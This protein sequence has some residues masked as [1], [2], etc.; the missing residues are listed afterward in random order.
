MS[1]RNLKHFASAPAANATHKFNGNTVQGSYDTSRKTIYET[2]DQTDG[3]APNTAPTGAPGSAN[4][5]IG[6]QLT[7]EITSP[8]TSDFVVSIITTTGAAIAGTTLTVTFRY[9]EVA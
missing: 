7:G 8:G 2:P 9:D 4:I 1:V 6:G 5:G 3:D